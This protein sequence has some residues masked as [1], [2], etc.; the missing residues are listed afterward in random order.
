MNLRVECAGDVLSRLTHHIEELL[1]LDEWPEITCVSDVVIEPISNTD[2]EPKME[3][4]DVLY[5]PSEIVD[6]VIPYKVTRIYETDGNR[7]IEALSEDPDKITLDPIQIPVSQIGKTVFLNKEAALLTLK[8]YQ[9]Y[10]ASEKTT[11]MPAT[12]LPKGWTWIMYAD[13]SGYL[14]SPDKKMYFE[15]DRDTDEYKITPDLSWSI[16]PGRLDD[17]PAFRLWAEEYVLKN[18]CN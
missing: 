12:L 16:E 15:Y 4:C 2:T 11:M 9:E 17:F 8:S 18:I 5:V 13:N 7:M 3:V 14:E 6:N 1:T 10:L